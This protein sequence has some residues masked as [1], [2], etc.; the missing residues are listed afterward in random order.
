MSADAIFIIGLVILGV[1]Y[2]IYS[3]V[4]RYFTYKENTSGMGNKDEEK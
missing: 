3:M 2:A 1:V 4:D